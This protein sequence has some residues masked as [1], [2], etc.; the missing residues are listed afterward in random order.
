MVVTARPSTS[1]TGVMQERTGLPSTCT[2]QAPQ[3]ATPHP[4]FVPVSLRCS[5]S[6]H[7]SGVSAPTL[8]SRRCPLTVNAAMSA[9][10]RKLCLLRTGYAG[11][12]RRSSAIGRFSPAATGRADAVEIACGRSSPHPTASGS[13]RIGRRRVGCASHLPSARRSRYGRSRRKRH[14]ST[15]PALHR[16]IAVNTMAIATQV[17]RRVIRDLLIAAP[18]KTGSAAARRN[19]NGC[20]ARRS[21]R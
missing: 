5:R 10:L 1:D 16:C 18:S 14:S 21:D 7:S 4:N 8:T 20:P 12:T 13:G 15:A 2:V 19:R 17:I 3:A 9:S 11:M 6:T